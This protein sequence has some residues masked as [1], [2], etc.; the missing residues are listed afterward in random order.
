MTDNRTSRISNYLICQLS[1]LAAAPADSLH[2][3]HS[4]Q[5]ACCALLA[6][7]FACRLCVFVLYVHLYVSEIVVSPRSGTIH[8]RG[9]GRSRRLD[10]VVIDSAGELLVRQYSKFVSWVVGSFLYF[11]LLYLSFCEDML[12]FL[13]FRKS[14]LIECYTFYTVCLYL[15]LINRS[16]ELNIAI[17][18]I[19]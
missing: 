4:E 16:I 11:V 5:L 8:F 12:T 13:G 15:L 6:E 1:A 3:L 7:L 19:I 17:S 9:V 14:K 18:A 10:C 2:V